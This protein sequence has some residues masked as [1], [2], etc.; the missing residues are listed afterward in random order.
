MSLEGS[1][2]YEQPARQCIRCSNRPCSS[3]PASCPSLA[4]IVCASSA[5]L[6]TL[7]AAHLHHPAKVGILPTWGGG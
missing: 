4:P 2:S 1:L 5:L 7:K 6:M 3:L